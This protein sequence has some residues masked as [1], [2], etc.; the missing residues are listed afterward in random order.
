MGYFSRTNWDA[1]V[2]YRKSRA[3]PTP[4]PVRILSDTELIEMGRRLR[5]RD[6]RTR[7]ASAPMIESKQRPEPQEG[8]G[9][10]GGS[11]KIGNRDYTWAELAKPE[12]R[13]AI[14]PQ[15][16][17]MIAAYKKNPEPWQAQGWSELDVQTAI[18]WSTG[19]FDGVPE[20]TMRAYRDEAV[21]AYNE[22]IVELGGEP[23][24]TTLTTG[25]QPP[26]ID[27]KTA[28]KELANLAKQPEVAIALQKR[29]TGQTLD[30]RQIAHA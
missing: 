1:S 14:M 20:E 15:V 16:E 13:R 25:T 9:V 21:T 30:A 10:M 11:I 22:K 6:E 4:E 2:P 26:A 23:M 29:S 24:A 5:Q 28:Y 7:L 3:K 12:V 17:A 18:R 19:A 27:G 8:Q